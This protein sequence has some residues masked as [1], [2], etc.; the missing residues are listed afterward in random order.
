MM[1]ALAMKPPQKSMTR[2]PMKTVKPPFKVGEL[3]AATCAFRAVSA[4]T[5]Y[6]FNA[7]VVPV[8]DKW[9]T[10]RVMP[11]ALAPFV[12]R[13]TDMKSEPLGEIRPSDAVREGMVHFN[14]TIAATEA[15]VQIWEKLYG[16]GSWERDY[17]K[18]IWAIGFEIAERRI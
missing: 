11:A 4:H 16:K 5:I 3:V 9:A 2:R 7:S 10:S 17:Y 18:R 1:R 15:F 8:D 14:P 13:I 12:L 6:R